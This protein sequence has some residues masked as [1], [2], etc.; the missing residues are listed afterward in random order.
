MRLVTIA[1]L[2]SLILCLQSKGAEP[3]RAVNDIIQL[4]AESTRL[5]KEGMDAMGARDFARALR[6]YEQLSEVY[7]KLRLM[8]KALTPE[9]RPLVYLTE[10]VVSGA[11]IDTLLK[12]VYCKRHLGRLKE[13]EEVLSEAK[14][15][16]L[17]L[18][19]KWRYL[20]YL[21][22][23]AMLRTAERKYGEAA[24]ILEELIASQKE[25]LAQIDLLGI[26]DAEQLHEAL[27]ALPVMNQLE[28]LQH[29]MFFWSC[30]VQAVSGHAHI[31]DMEAALAVCDQPEFTRL[32]EFFVLLDGVL[33][34]EKGKND[35]ALAWLRS[36]SGALDLTGLAV[37]AYSNRCA[38]LNE[39]GRYAESL[40]QCDSALALLP[41]GKGLFQR[42]I[43]LNN[44]GYGRINLK[45]YPQAMASFRECLANAEKLPSP[46]KDIWETTARLNSAFVLRQSGDLQGAL[47]NAEKAIAAARSLK[48]PELLWVGLSSRG[49]TLYYLERYRE[50]YDSLKECIDIIEDLRSLLSSERHR[51]TFMTDKTE[52]YDTMIRVLEKL[53]LPSASFEYAERAKARAFIDLLGSENKARFLK[54]SVTPAVRRE[55]EI[56]MEAM[57]K[58]IEKRTELDLKMRGLSDGQQGESSVEETVGTQQD[59][60]TA[61][62]LARLVSNTDAE[63]AD[64]VLVRP[65]DPREMGKLLGPDTLLVEYSAGNED[66]PPL[67]FAA[68][69][70]TLE[71]TGSPAITEMMCSGGELTEAVAA[72]RRLLASPA[73]SP[74][75]IE[76]QSKELYRLLL[77]P[78]EERLNGKK[79][80]IIVPHGPLNFLPFAALM[81]D[82]GA[83]LVD[84]IDIAYLPSST[85]LRFCREKNTGKTATIAAYALGDSAH[86]SLSALPG[87]LS[88]VESLKPLFAPGHG[89]FVFE[90]TLT[91]GQFEELAGRK[92]IVHLAT[93][94]L[95]DFAS[96]MDSSIIL[97]KNRLQVRDVMALELRANLVTLSACKTGLGKLYT[98]DEIVG[99]TRAFIYAGTPSV[100]SSLWSVSDE[101]TAKLMTAFYRHLHAGQDKARA[102]RNAQN[103]IRREFTSP[104]FWACFIL[105]GDWR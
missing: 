2:L 19:D 55:V 86:E 78:L 45:Q 43:L 18:G 24:D 48:D 60:E 63:F 28:T 50:A 52:V 58:T 67:L 85:A 4:Q 38:V 37:I 31:K 62:R 13:T 21:N 105:T 34:S 1:L 53:K 22:E 64:L 57:G 91:A 65:I 10:K 11:L 9:E 3:S 26:K 23:F 42:A 90:E 6:C 17:E 40:K 41:P 103:D 16:S 61:A 12:V 84:R 35:P 71:N 74:A 89:T 39:L 20:Q 75:L 69:G 59:R 49:K 44:Q 94:G 76:E 79:R 95:L 27:A 73:A 33:N 104:F 54:K 97:G 14:S 46:E 25:L 96:P 80:L 30:Y 83:F 101:S 29:L 68:D 47:A 5:T 82:G 66:F 81:D 32:S 87:T 15:L 99:L 70:A 92:D 56:L 98:G 7:R 100:L 93:H 102:L 8:I 51:R 36:A 72:F 77:H 88:E